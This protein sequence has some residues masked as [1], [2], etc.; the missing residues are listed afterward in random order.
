MSVPV[1]FADLS[2]LPFMV[3]GGAGLLIIAGV[4]LAIAAALL[5]WVKRNRAQR[6]VEADDEPQLF[7]DLDQDK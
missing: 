1:F 4:F 6:D 2:P 5:G 3:F 7:P